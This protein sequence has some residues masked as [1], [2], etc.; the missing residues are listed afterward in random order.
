L[1]E[2]TVRAGAPG[3]GVY[4]EAFAEAELEGEDGEPAA[5]DEEA[6]DALAGQ[7]EL[8]DEVRPDG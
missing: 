5:F 7:G 1:V 8:A 3:P 4:G 2:I 6:Q